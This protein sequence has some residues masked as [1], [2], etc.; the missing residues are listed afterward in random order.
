MFRLFKI[1]I[2]IVNIPIKIEKLKWIWIPLDY[3]SIDFPLDSIIFNH[4]IV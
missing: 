1:N 3:P 2:I 4:N